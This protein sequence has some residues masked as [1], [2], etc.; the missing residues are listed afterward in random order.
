MRSVRQLVALLLCGIAVCA[1]LTY[2]VRLSVTPPKETK[3]ADDFY[4]QRAFY[5]RLRT[6]LLE[7]GALRAVSVWGIETTDS[8]GWITS[9]GTLS[10]SRYED[11]LSLLKQ[12]N[13]K[14]ASRENDS[15]MC[16]L[17]WRAGF[18]GDTRHRDVCWLNEEPRNEVAS[19]EQF[20]RTSKP[21]KPS[22]KHL[23]SN[24]YIW[25]DW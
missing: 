12:L 25:A 18:A 20:E 22:Y 1:L 3:I 17:V 2:G 7:D 4:R 21:R 13:A 10:A 15:A 24:W 16:V 9:K 19:L 11:Y 8:A 6:M 14:A 23:Q 5:E